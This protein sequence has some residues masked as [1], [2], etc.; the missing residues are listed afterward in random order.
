MV[1][2][3]K[4]VLNVAEEEV[5]VEDYRHNQKLTDEAQADAIA[6]IEEYG[7]VQ[8]EN[9]KKY[10]CDCHFSVTTTCSK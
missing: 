4:F 2:D 5:N 1:K 3:R 6:D 7:Y 8:Y 9:H 10:Q